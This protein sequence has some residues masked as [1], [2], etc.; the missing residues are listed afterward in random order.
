MLQWAANHGFV[1]EN[2]LEL[3]NMALAHPRKS[4]SLFLWGLRHGWE[5]PPTASGIPHCPLHVLHELHRRSVPLGPKNARRYQR[6]LARVKALV[7][8]PSALIDLILAY[9]PESPRNAGED[10]RRGQAASPLPT[11]SCL[12]SGP[13]VISET[14]SG[15]HRA[16]P[17]LLHVST[18]WPAEEQRERAN[19]LRP[20]TTLERA[21]AAGCADCQVET[22]PHHVYKQYQ[23]V[24]SRIA[25]RDLG[26]VRA[27]ERQLMAAPSRPEAGQQ[28]RHL[29]DATERALPHHVSLRTHVKQWDQERA[30]RTL[31]AW[32]QQLTRHLKTLMATVQAQQ[33]QDQTDWKPLMR[34]LH[35]LDVDLALWCVDAARYG[36][37]PWLLGPVKRAQALVTLRRLHEQLTFLHERLGPIEPHVPFHLQVDVRLLVRRLAKVLT[38]V[39]TLQDRW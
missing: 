10:R 15:R 36:R 23:V 24:R 26:P 4:W 38:C 34:R 30:L 14:P 32:Q 13:D 22:D 16:R 6:A 25:P 31:Q 20:M 27:A 19:G 1:P 33:G 18:L 7:P 37:T 5:V 28:L 35:E 17:P 39:Q 8:A 2:T 21:F 9:L 11:S 3:M 29:L 12:W